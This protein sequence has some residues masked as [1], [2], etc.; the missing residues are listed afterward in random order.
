[1]LAGADSTSVS[2]G[3]RRFEQCHD[4]SKV[5]GAPLLARTA[6]RSKDDDGD[7]TMMHIDFRESIFEVVLK[8]STPTQIYDR[9][10][11]LY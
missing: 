5:S 1:M 9:I 7:L 10:L 4:S 8:K 2:D 6:S 11:Y 3:W